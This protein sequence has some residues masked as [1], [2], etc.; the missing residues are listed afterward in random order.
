MDNQHGRRCCAVPNYLDW[1][2]GAAGRSRLAGYAAASVLPRNTQYINLV[3][4]VGDG[5]EL[6]E[7]FRHRY[8]GLVRQLVELELIEAESEVQTILGR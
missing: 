6:Q 3:Y 2:G 5:S 8:A 7:Y 1:Q 4:D